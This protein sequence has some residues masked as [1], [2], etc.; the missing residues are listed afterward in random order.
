M[1]H[2]KIHGR[3]SSFS[4]CFVGGRFVSHE[5]PAYVIIIFH[6]VADGRRMDVTRCQP[7]NNT[8]T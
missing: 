7:H 1:L 3:F 5:C 6:H 2:K 4:E 8:R